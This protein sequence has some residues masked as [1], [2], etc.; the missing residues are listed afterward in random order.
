MD[1]NTLD[2]DAC[3]EI[4]LNWVLDP[5]RFTRLHNKFAEKND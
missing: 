2:L 1:L 5:S 4:S 3:P